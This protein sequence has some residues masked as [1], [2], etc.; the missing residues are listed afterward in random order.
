MATATEPLECSRGTESTPAPAWAAS[1]SQPLSISPALVQL[2]RWLGPVPMVP[3]ADLLLRREDRRAGRRALRIAR[4][5]ADRIFAVEDS[6]LPL[7]EL[8]DVARRELRTGRNPAPAFLDSLAL[9]AIAAHRVL[10]LRPH[11]AQI[12]AAVSVLQGRATELGCGEGK[13][14]AL[15]LAA[16]VRALGGTPVHLVLRDDR[17]V[18]SQAALLRPFFAALGLELGAL[19]ASSTAAAR[20]VAYGAGVCIATARELARDHL[21]GPAPGQPRRE[22]ACAFV[23]DI[24]LLLIDEALERLETPAATQ[25]AVTPQAFFSRYAALGGTSATLAE[26]RRELAALYGMGVTTIGS[27]YPCFRR[28][29]GTAVSASRR[30]WLRRVVERVQAHVAGRRAVLVTAND[31]HAS[32]LLANALQAAGLDAIRIG[33]V[34]SVGMAHAGQVLVCTD[35]L[36]ACR[37]I[38][39]DAFARAAGGLAVVATDLAATRRA[40]RRLGHLAGHRG[41]PGSFETIAA[42]PLHGAIAHLPPPLMRSFVLARRLLAEWRAERR[43][44]LQACRPSPRQA[45]ETMPSPRRTPYLQHEGS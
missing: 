22:S 5:A 25:P 33:R 20:Q 36:V 12:A 2:A 31:D 8:A 17:D 3:L 14:L 1:G 26:A 19:T 16:A 39:V 32:A 37:R 11:L 13:S 7:G 30:E 40:Q 10:G 4:V 43:R 38:E 9:A 15:A 35:P 29:L 34:G 41:Q 21:Q 42:P 28:E 6:R 27:I 18:E 44:G 45:P 24:D 23:D